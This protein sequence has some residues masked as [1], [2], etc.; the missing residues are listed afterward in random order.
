ME[1]KNLKAKTRSARVALPGIE[2][3]VQGSSV[4]WPFVL[5]P[6]QPA[7]GQLKGGALPNRQD[8]RPTDPYYTQ[9]VAPYPDPPVSYN[10][11]VNP[12]DFSAD[13][14]DRLPGPP[15]PTMCK[16][17][18]F[19]RPGRAARLPYD[20][21]TNRVQSRGRTTYITTLNY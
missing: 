13:R 17:P 1:A 20:A 2:G 10:V 18:T 15:V 9:L 5:A 16:F 3:N 21:S 19:Y 4:S 14:R 6:V 11:R 12:A 7:N 8:T